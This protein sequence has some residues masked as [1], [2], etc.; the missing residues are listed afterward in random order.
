MIKPKSPTPYKCDAMTIHKACSEDAKAVAAL[1]VQLAAHEGE[2]TLCSAASVTRLLAQPREPQCEIFVAKE[3]GQ[4]IGFA[5]VYPGY[6]LSSDSYGYHL[7]DICVEKSR[8]NHGIGK[9]LLRHIAAHTLTQQKEWLSLTVL[10]QNKTARAFYQSLKMRDL[11][12][13]FMA[14]GKQVLSSF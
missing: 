2:A 3:E 12:V 13:T 14:A 11:P 5:M 4:I 7:A 10:K 9:K 8:R 1:A 6:D